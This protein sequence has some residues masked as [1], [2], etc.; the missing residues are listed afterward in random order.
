MHDAGEQT[1]REVARV[2][3]ARKFDFLGRLGVLAV[4]TRRIGIAAVGAHQ[5]VDHE[6]QGRG[7]WYQFTGVTIM[8]PC[9]AT[10][11]G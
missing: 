5:P 1:S 8:M 6:L 3:P 4:S 10:H 9:A 11:I 2:V 7:A